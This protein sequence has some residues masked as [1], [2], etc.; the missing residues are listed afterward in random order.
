MY[1]A[2]LATAVNMTLVRLG[3][4]SKQRPVYFI[5]KALS[6]AETRYTNFEPVVVALRMATKKIR[7]Y[8][9]AHTIIVLTGS[10][11]R[12]ILHKPYASRRLLEWVIELSKIDIEY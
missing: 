2:V 10:S 1:L 7:L 12:A 6:E 9:Q 11:I 8:F 4:Y 5:S 3:P